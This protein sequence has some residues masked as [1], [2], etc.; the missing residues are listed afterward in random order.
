M[1]SSN[2]GVRSGEFHKTKA[3]YK[4]LVV[5]RISDRMKECEGDGSQRKSEA[6]EKECRTSGQIYMTDLRCL[7]I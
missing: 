2:D 3:Q 5:Q 7:Q 1:Y 4:N 6:V